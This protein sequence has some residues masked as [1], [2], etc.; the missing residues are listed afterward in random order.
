MVL[1]HYIG[2]FPGGTHTKLLKKKKKKV[3]GHAELAVVSGLQC[4][5]K[6]KQ[7]SPEHTRMLKIANCIMP[8][9]GQWRCIY[10]CSWIRYHHCKPCTYRVRSALRGCVNLSPRND[11]SSKGLELYASNTPQYSW[12]F[13]VSLSLSS[14]MPVC[15][16]RIKEK[17]EVLKS[18]QLN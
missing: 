18:T 1:F 13:P 9:L 5:C 2:S 14:Y 11:L 12:H 8:A 17:E 16:H 10:S 3:S 7:T 15:C 4:S 6:A